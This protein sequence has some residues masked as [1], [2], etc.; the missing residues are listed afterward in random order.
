MPSIT[1]EVLNKCETRREQKKHNF[2]ND[3]EVMKYR[4][5]NKETKK[6]I[7]KVRNN[8][9]QDQIIDIEN[10]LAKNNTRKAYLLAKPLTTT[11]QPRINI[12]QDKNGKLLPDEKAATERWTEYNSN[13]YNHEAEVDE[14]IVKEPTD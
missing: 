2:E 1:A 11:K 12:N 14:N 13:L 7:T 4:K 10:N 3:E 8:E 9:I 6:E 5:V